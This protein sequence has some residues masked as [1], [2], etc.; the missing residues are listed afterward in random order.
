MTPGSDV[1]PRTSAELLEHDGGVLRRWIRGVEEDLAGA[2]AVAER[3]A[4]VRAATAERKR[5]SEARAAAKRAKEETQA[6]AR[7]ETGELGLQQIE[8]LVAFGGVVAVREY[9]VW[10]RG[11]SAVRS[12]IR[13]ELEKLSESWLWPEVPDAKDA[14]GAVRP[15]GTDGFWRAGKGTGFGSGTPWVCHKA[16]LVEAHRKDYGL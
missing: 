14:I 16:A 13:K 10:R 6:A 4:A 3:Q 11:E 8:Q 7:R 5:V 12:D 15:A 1:A 2:A 9:L